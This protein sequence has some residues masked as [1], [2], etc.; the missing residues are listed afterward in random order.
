MPFWVI[1]CAVY[2]TEYQVKDQ[3]SEKIE[4]SFASIDHECE[5]DVIIK[6]IAGFIAVTFT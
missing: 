5:I 4:G 3:W 6:R 2:F 1:G